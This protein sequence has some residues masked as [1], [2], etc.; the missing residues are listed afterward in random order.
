M[1]K[2]LLKTLM[3]PLCILLAGM[4]ITATAQTQVVKGLVVDP[5]GNPLPGVTVYAEGKF[6]STDQPRR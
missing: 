1:F 5:A 4:H 6:W 2:K 3:L